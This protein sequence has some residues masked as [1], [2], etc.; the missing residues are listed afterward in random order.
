MRREALTHPKIRLRKLVM[1]SLIVFATAVSLLM[2]DH[3]AM[4]YEES[5]WNSFGQ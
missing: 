5:C 2:V 4:G 3:P 1:C